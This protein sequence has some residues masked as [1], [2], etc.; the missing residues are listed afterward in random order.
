MNVCAILPITDSNCMYIMC[1]AKGF[2][3]L[4]KDLNKYFASVYYLFFPH[5]KERRDSNV[6]VTK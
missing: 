1:K 4:A 5:K 3:L 2:F 6:S